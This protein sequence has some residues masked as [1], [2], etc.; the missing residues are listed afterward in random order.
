[1][2]Y[3]MYV[4]VVLM[5]YLIGSIPFGVILTRIFAHKDIRQTGSGKIGMT[6]VLR[7]A[8]KKA[9]AL[10]LLLDLGKGALSAF[11][12]MLIFQSAYVTGLVDDSTNIAYY[13][14]A[15]ASLAAVG[16]HTWSLFLKFT[17]GRGVNT[18]LGGL[19]VMYWPAAVLGGALMIIVGLVS[20]YMSLGSISGAVAAFVMLIIVFIIKAYPV[21]YMTYTTYTLIGAIF[22]FIMHHDNVS[23]LV[24]GTE[25]RL[26]QNA[27]SESL[28]APDKHDL[29]ENPDISM[30]V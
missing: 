6:N 24:S 9:A 20:K 26:G 30:K 18:F 23:R 14:Q 21:E 28:Q 1:M 29:T 19:L 22:I 25:R 8:G 2:I 15:L 10:A 3:A 12:A 16:G 7:T 11:A 17:G 13:A 27:K 4:V 5:G